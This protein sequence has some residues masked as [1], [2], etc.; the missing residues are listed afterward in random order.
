MRSTSR[1]TVA[2][3]ATVELAVIVVVFIALVTI[4]AYVVQNRQNASNMLSGSTTSEPKLGTTAAIEKT[5]ADD[6]TT[7]SRADTSADTSAQQNALSA[8]AT[9]SNVGGTYDESTL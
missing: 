4:G 3:M 5:A 2:G 6:A 9:I 7:E 1:N 8:N